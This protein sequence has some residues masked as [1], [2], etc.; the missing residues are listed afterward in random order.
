MA[1]RI[2][3]SCKRGFGEGMFVLGSDTL[4]CALLTHA[5]VPDSGHATFADVAAAEVSGAGYATGGAILS[6]VTW[7]VS[8]DA[9]VL[10]AA[11][12]SWAGATITAR[13]AVVYAVKTAGGLTNPLLC[14]LDFGQDIG[15]TGGTFS[16]AF[17][18]AG[19]LVLE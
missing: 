8:G 18:A 4:K 16:V 10:D 11:D 1:N 5:Y 12:P 9:A 3:A 15:V 7:G 2:Y 14:L 6:G 19:V 13:Y 17:D